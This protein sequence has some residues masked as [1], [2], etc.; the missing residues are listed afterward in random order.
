MKERDAGTILRLPVSADPESNA[1]R[2]AQALLKQQKRR[3]MKEEV[4]RL[5]HGSSRSE[6]GS[7]KSYF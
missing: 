4:L 6:E 1:G 7:R 2:G 3:R 5:S